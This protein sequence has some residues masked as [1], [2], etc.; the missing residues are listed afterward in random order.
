MPKVGRKNGAWANKYYLQNFEFQSLVVNVSIF[1][2]AFL[3]E[4]DS[5]IKNFAE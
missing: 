4:T 1:K 5:V 2:N 3:H